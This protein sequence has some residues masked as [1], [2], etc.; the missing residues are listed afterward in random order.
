[1]RAEALR[2]TQAL[3]VLAGAG[4]PGGDPGRPG[5]GAAGR[6]PHLRQPAPRDALFYA[7][8][9]PALPADKTYQLWF[10]A[11]GKPVPAGTFAVDAR[12]TA[13]L[14]VERVAGR[15]ERSRPGR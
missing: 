6:G 4:R 8:D 11:G 13:S 15:R 5:T 3:Q 12:G 1:M 7:F 14:R 9:L 10:I 2:A